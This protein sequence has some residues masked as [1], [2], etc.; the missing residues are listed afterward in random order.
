MGKECGQCQWC[1]FFKYFE[2]IRLHWLFHAGFREIRFL[3]WCGVINSNSWFLA[4][5]KGFSFR[6]F[7]FTVFKLRDCQQMTF[8]TLN[9][10]CPLNKPP[11]PRFYP[12]IPRWMQYQPKLNENTHPFYILFEVWKVLIIIICKM[13]PLDP[14]FLV[15]LC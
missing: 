13:Q 8:V 6:M 15:V 2:G 12:T 9:G 4:T 5:L 14:L 7:A 1:Y 10:F 3:K 11:P